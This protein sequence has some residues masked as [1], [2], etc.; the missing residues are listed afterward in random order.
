[1]SSQSDQLNI[2]GIVFN[3]QDDE[4]TFFKQFVRE[5]DGKNIS[6]EGSTI[7][8]DGGDD[9][10]SHP[11]LTVYIFKSSEINND[12]YAFMVDGYSDDALKHNWVKK[13]IYQDDREAND[14][15]FLNEFVLAL[16]DR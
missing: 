16:L 15:L 9:E 2:I 11:L 14:T 1:M 4:K 3:S 8:V 12:V 7:M 5:V 13:I 10:D 6:I